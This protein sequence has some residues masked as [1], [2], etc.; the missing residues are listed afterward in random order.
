MRQ[1]D[2][3]ARVE[4]SNQILAERAVMATC[5]GAGISGIKRQRS[6]ASSPARMACDE[7]L[8]RA[9]GE[10]RR[11]RATEELHWLVAVYANISSRLLFQLDEM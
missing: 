4:A 2:A 7:E 6:L 10:A 3:G 5:G 11:C 8:P 9:S 1:Y